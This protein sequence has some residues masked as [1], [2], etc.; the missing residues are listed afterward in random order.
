[1]TKEQK[2][3]YGAFLNKV[4]EILGL[5]KPVDVLKLCAVMDEYIA[6]FQKHIS[7]L[8]KDCKYF[9]DNLDLQIEATLKLQN[10]NT[11]L[12]E[13]QKT[14]YIKGIRHFAKALKEYDRKN[15]SWTD[16]FEHT[17]NE[18]L[19]RELNEVEIC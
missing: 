4:S 13:K 8:E 6:P 15:G 11:E 7:E 2:E 19:K 10:E 16:Y 1:M 9:S 17:V 12:K 18:V 14:A 3:R 5:N